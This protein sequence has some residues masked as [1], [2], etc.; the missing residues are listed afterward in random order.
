MDKF[1]VIDGNREEAERDLV[2]ALLTPWD[3]QRLTDAADKIM[4]KGKLKLVSSA[5]RLP[6]EPEPHDPSGAGQN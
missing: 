1:K 4:P 6:D 3:K 5:S 2:E